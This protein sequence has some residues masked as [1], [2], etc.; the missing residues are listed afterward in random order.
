MKEAT[1]HPRGELESKKKKKFSRRLLRRKGQ[2]GSALRYI[3]Q[4]S[5]SNN[6][7]MAPL[8]HPQIRDGWFHEGG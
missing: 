8:S 2:N 5:L 3:F 7:N 4:S 6:I 1:K